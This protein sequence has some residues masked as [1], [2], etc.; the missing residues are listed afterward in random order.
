MNRRKFV[1]NNLRGAVGFASAAVSAVL[2][3][4]AAPI[5]LP[6]PAPTKRPEL[7]VG[8]KWVYA[9]INRY[10]N[11][12]IA[13][14]THEVTSISP[15]IRIARTDDKGNSQ[16]EEIYDSQWAVRQEPSYEQTQVF[17]TPLP[18]LPSRL[19][20]GVA[21]DF[22]TAYRVAQNNS[23]YAW[24]SRLRAVGWERVRVPAG[25]FTALRIERT[26]YFAHYDS[27]RF[28][29]TRTDTL[30]FVPEINHWVRREWTGSYRSSGSRRIPLRE[31][32]VRWDLL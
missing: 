2:P 18:L 15:L 27:F 1:G 26:F 31:D 8:Q 10:N 24:N 19:E 16:A 5:F 6:A 11:L 17:Q 13:T 21:E 3:G 23:L 14:V 22:S 7:R 25:E 4:C 29:N 12:Q 28:D 32:W 30:W 9:E 20:A